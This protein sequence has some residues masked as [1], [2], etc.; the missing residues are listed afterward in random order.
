MWAVMPPENVP[1]QLHVAVKGRPA[2]GQECEV[3]FAVCVC[4]VLGPQ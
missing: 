3:H 4:A 1:Q 2:Y